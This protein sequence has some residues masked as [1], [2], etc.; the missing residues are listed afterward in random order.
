M[1]KTNLPTAAVT[2]MLGAFSFGII[3]PTADAVP[4]TGNAAIIAVAANPTIE[5]AYVKKKIVVKK[6]G[7][8]KTTRIYSRSRY[9]RGYGYY[10]FGYYHPPRAYSCGKFVRTVRYVHHRRVVRVVRRGC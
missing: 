8:K 2:A 5:A 6:K 10:G 1:L 7:Y 9:H 3:A 4:T